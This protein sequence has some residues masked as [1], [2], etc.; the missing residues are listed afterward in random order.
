MNDSNNPFGNNGVPQTP[1]PM[2]PNMPMNNAAPVNPMQPNNGFSQQPVGRAPVNNIPTSLVQAINGGNSAPAS[3]APVNNNMNQAPVNQAPMNGIPTSL[4][5]AINGGVPAAPVQP[6]NNAVP[7]NNGGVPQ[8]PMNNGMSTPQPMGGTIAPQDRFISVSE[9]NEN[10]FNQDDLL[11]TFIGKNCSKIL[12]SNFN[13]AAFFFGLY[14]MCYRKMYGRSVLIFLLIIVAAFAVGFLAPALSGI[15]PLVIWLSEGFYFNKMYIAHALKKIEKIRTNNPMASYEEL[16]AICSRK[17]GTSIG[18]IF[19]G[20]IT[21]HAILFVLYV[22]ISLLFVGLIISMFT[23]IGLT[24]LGK[25]NNSYNN[26]TSYYSNSIYGSNPGCGSN[27][28]NGILLEDVY[29]SGSECSIYNSKNAFVCKMRIVKNDSA[30]SG[31]VST[32]VYGLNDDELF[33]TFNDFLYKDDLKID[34]Y[35]TEGNDVF[36]NNYDTIVGYKV[37]LKETNEDI[38]CIKSERELEEK[39]G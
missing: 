38:T 35:Y 26:N 17:G 11:Q 2:N 21:Y 10:D 6:Q 23:G 5:Q 39:L 20:F 31:H 37:Y 4:T 3:P 22:I 24:D 28:I 14:Y 27:T 36:D 1:Q 33:S 32:Y 16:D 8:Q 7:I 12:S 34:I 9:V 29:K 19:L 18:L 30:Y 15:L 13:F 25:N